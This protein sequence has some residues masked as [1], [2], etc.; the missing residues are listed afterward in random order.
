MKK[1]FVVTCW[2]LFA[3]ISVNAA[4]IIEVDFRKNDSL[5][6]FD[7]AELKDGF[8]ILKGGK[9]RAEDLRSQKHHRPDEGR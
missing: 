1:F 5:R 4:K 9:S 3:F 8:L 6:L 7:G 2:C